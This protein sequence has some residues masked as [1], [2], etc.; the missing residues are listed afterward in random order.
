MS[1][2]EIPSLSSVI[3]SINPTQTD[4]DQQSST[5][6]TPINSLQSAIDKIQE[7]TGGTVQPEVK[8]VPADSHQQGQVASESPAQKA[9]LREMLTQRGL[10]VPDELNTDELIVE[11]LV[12][13]F[14]HAAEAYESPEYKA[15]LD[16][17]S[18]QAIAEKAKSE[19][20]VTPATGPQSQEILNAVRQGIV[21]FDGVQKKWIASHP[22]F[23]Q[24]ADSM[25]SQDLRANQAKISFASDP[26]GFIAQKIRESAGDLKPSSEIAELKEL[27]QQIRQERTDQAEQGKIT[28]WENANLAKLYV[29]G[30]GE[31]T[32]YGKAYQDIETSISKINPK[33]GLL[34]RHNQVLQQ[35][36]IV[37]KYL[38]QAKPVVPEPQAAKT[39]FL[40]A[41]SR[42]NGTNRLSDYSGPASN[43]VAPQIPKGKQGYPSLIGIIEQNSALGS[44]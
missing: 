29:T 36:A 41:A 9:F 30:S 39:S 8:P 4:S 2:P 34:E 26:E 43:S 37:E 19:P 35:L 17:Q 14:N 27:I 21:S 33:I 44:N 23:E 20:P 31:M 42:R 38:P 10:S 18:K 15:F 22:Q 11:S 40:D 7:T 13:E 32:N 3:D 6:R 16:W 12:N 28:T 5:P 25:N 24:Y 1:G